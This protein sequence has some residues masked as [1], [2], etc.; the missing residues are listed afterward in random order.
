LVQQ[1]SEFALPAACRYQKLLSFP[2]L[3]L[4]TQGVRCIFANLSD[5]GRAF[6]VADAVENVAGNIAAIGKA[7][8]GRVNQVGPG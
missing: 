2:R 3:S 1:I 7:L 6:R 8:Q 4:L 5:F